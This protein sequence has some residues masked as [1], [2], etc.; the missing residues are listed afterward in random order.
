MY[1]SLEEAHKQTWGATAH[2]SAATASGVAH[3]REH[4]AQLAAAL[5]CAR[6]QLRHG[7]EPRVR[8]HVAVHRRSGEEEASDA[9]EEALRQG[10]C[11]E[12]IAQLVQDAGPAKE[13]D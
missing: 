2:R 9:W 4:D 1:E 7:S 12:R 3:A 5:P 11:A 8:A 10:R 13:G 6:E